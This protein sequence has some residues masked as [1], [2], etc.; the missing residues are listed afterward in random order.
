[1][2]Q[3][4]EKHITGYR[5][6]D[7]AENKPPSLRAVDGQGGG[8]AMSPYYHLLTNLVNTIMNVLKRYSFI[9][10]DY[11]LTVKCIQAFD[12]LSCAC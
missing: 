10:M 12:H 8:S 3:H 9:S 7:D 4:D 1:V 6:A 5:S 2:K 11:Q